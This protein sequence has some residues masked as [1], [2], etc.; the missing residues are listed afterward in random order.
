MT[1][2]RSARS[3]ESVVMSPVSMNPKSPSHGAGLS[4]D[5]SGNAALGGAGGA[6]LV[7]GGAISAG[8]IASA[9]N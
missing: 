5:G 3:L 1:N 7:A 8:A 9:P 6:G 2:L 4:H